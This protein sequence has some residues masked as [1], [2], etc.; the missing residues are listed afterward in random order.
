MIIHRKTGTYIVGYIDLL[1][2]TNKINSEEQQFAMNKLYNLY[3]FSIGATKAC[4]GLWRCS[5][6][7]IFFREYGFKLPYN[8]YNYL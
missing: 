6:E 5:T 7:I 4:Y 1:G 8:N 3:T 2:V